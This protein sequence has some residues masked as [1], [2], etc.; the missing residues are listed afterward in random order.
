MKVDIKKIDKIKRTIKVEAC[1]E[2]FLGEK[3]KVYSAAAKK[4]KVPGFR[5]GSAPLDILEKHHSKA[6]REELLQ[7]A[8]S[9]F[10]RQALEENKIIP[11]SMPRIYDVELGTDK[12]SFTA[13]FEIRPEIEVKEATYKEIKVKAKISEVKEI[14]IEK[15]ITNLKEGVKK[16]LN[17]DLSDQDLA[18]WA[19][20]A[21]TEDLRQAI[22]GQLYV[23]KLRQRRQEVENQVKGQLLKSVKVDLPKAEVDRHHKELLDREVYNL[24][25]RGISQQDLDKYKTDLETKLRPVAEE[26]IKLFYI[27]E[28]IARQENIK[29]E[30]NLADVVF[31]FVLSQA[32][33][34]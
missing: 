11:A 14:E 1:G 10:Y 2:Q 5:P 9:L 13:D 23:E 19:S 32:K 28:A 21:N 3:N 4:L 29:A 6:L 7:S 27:L 30:N 22:K 34:E 25:L 26:E 20:Y 12:L 33:Y 8:L 24:S 18:R 31:S 15:V 17:K 16:V